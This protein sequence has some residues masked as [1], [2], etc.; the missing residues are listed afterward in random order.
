MQLPHCGDRELPT[1][2]FTVVLRAF[3]PDQN[4]TASLN[5]L[6]AKPLSFQISL[7]R[8][9]KAAKVLACELPALTTTH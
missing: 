2:A 6:E 8:Y 5:M 7:A 4:A 1:L 9:S 3:A